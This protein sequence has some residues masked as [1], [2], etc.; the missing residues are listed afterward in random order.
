MFNKKKKVKQTHI[1]FRTLDKLLK[2]K[3]LKV[4]KIEFFENKENNNE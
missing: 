3:L 2:L 4:V 1:F